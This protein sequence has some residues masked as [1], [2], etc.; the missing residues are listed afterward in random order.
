MKMAAAAIECVSYSLYRMVL[1]GAS[2][3]TSSTVLEVGGFMGS[4]RCEEGEGTVIDGGVLLYNY[5]AMFNPQIS[6]EHTRP[7]GYYFMFLPSLSSQQPSLLYPPLTCFPRAGVI[8]NTVS[9][10][11]PNKA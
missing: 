9:I 8:A 7:Q 2:C 4:L 1:R 10:G 6:S 5:T 3:V 11:N